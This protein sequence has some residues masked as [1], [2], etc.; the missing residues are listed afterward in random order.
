MSR[1][2]IYHII[3]SFTKVTTNCVNYSWVLT[4][5]HTMRHVTSTAAIWLSMELKSSIYYCL[6]HQTNYWQSLL[7]SWRYNPFGFIFTAQQR[8]LASFSRFLDH[9]QRRATVGRT[10]LDEWSICRRDLYLRTHNT[11]N[12]QTS[13]PPV[14]FEP[15]ISAGEQPK[16]YALDRAATG[17][18]ADRVY[19]DEFTI[20][21]IRRICL[22]GGQREIFTTY[23][24]HN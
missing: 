11:H 7:F 22:H 24:F 19:H 5:L 2:L 4:H 13:I 17:T 1:S 15:T 14:G 10:S 9:T 3:S 23:F 12:R 8:A 16:T 6:G 21:P 18:G 20:P